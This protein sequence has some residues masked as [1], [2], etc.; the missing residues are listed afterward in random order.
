MVAFEI[1]VRKVGWRWPIVQEIF[2]EDFS[3]NRAVLILI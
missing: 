1:I 2:K 3:G